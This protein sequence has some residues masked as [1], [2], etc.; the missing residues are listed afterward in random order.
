MLPHPNIF[1]AKKENGFDKAQKMMGLNSLL[2]K[3]REK[4]QMKNKKCR[5]QVLSNNES[6]TMMK[7]RP[8][9]LS[10]PLEDRL[11]CEGN[12]MFK[13]DQRPMT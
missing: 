2:E 11:K 6:P 7:Y 8:V 5:T 9:N 4:S 10:K 1:K 12:G 3:E 13:V